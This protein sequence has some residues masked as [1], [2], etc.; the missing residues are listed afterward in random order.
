[1]RED[2][3]ILMD[4]TCFYATSGGQ[5]GDT[6]FFERENGDKIVIAGTVTGDTKAEIIH[7][8]RPR[9]VNAEPRREAGAAH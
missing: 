3:G 6:G 7:I 8:P 5:P 4:Q 9:P 2:G 1:M